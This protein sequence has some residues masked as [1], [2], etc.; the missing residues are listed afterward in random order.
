MIGDGS[1]VSCFFFITPGG[2]PAE[3]A[4]GSAQG[5]SEPVRQE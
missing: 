2:C 3:R 5:A 4:E 1:Q